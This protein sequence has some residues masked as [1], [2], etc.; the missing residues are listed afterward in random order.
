MRPY[1]TY[2]GISSLE[3]LPVEL[4]VCNLEYSEKVYGLKKEYITTTITSENDKE[5]YLGALHSTPIEFTFSLIKRNG[6]RF[7]FLEI[8]ALNNWLM[9]NNFPKKLKLHSKDCD[10][11]YYYNGVITEVN[12]IRA[13]G[14]I[15]IEC[16]FKNDSAFMYKDNILTFDN[17]SGIVS[18]ECETDN[19]ESYIYPLITIKP[20]V[21]DNKFKIINIDDENNELK[22]KIQKDNILTVDCE[23]S[24]IFDFAEVNQS[25]SDIG[26]KNISDIYWIKLKNGE[27]NL[28]LSVT[29]GTVDIKITY[30]SKIFGGVLDE[31]SV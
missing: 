24:V 17:K 12:Q 25:F 18:F 8:R 6:E 3:I 14:I 4:V 22:I 26:W 28:N 27:N 9:K 19:T 11:I 10:G 23:N 20:N 30:V 15:G 7:N 21:T 5:K 31:F 29:G 16:H 1:I 13:G 2:N